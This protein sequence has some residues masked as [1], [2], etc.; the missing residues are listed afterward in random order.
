MN[1]DLFLAILTINA[2]NRGY[3]VGISGLN[4][5]GKIG[6]ASIKNDSLVLGGT[7]ENRLDAQSGFYA[8]A[9]GLPEGAVAGVSGTVVPC[10]GTDTKRDFFSAYCIGI[11]QPFALTG[12]LTDAARLTI[13]QVGCIEA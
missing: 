6:K 8:I 4:A 12:G 2:Y 13:E 7:L 11:G 10:R 9:Y 1:R 3:G 5:F